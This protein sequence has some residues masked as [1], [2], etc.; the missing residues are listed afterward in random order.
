MHA[1]TGQDCDV[2]ANLPY[3]VCSGE[4]EASQLYRLSRSTRAD[5]EAWCPL[6]FSCSSTS[7][8]MVERAPI[9]LEL[10][11]V[12][13]TPELGWILNSTSRD[14]VSRICQHDMLRSGLHEV[15]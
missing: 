6:Q 3:A 9:G 12:H 11:L 5:E 10:V 13:S 2:D 14:A 15:V 8:R 4:A 1:R 7:S